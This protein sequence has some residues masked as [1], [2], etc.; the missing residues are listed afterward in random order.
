MEIDDTIGLN[1]VNINV[2]ESLST[3]EPCGIGNKS[4]VFCINRATVKNLRFVNGKYVSYR[5]ID[6]AHLR[7]NEMALKE[8]AMDGIWEAIFGVKRSKIEPKKNW[9]N[10]FLDNFR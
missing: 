8:K 9:F 4:P 7:G 2:I 6:Q 3:L 1:D 10:K 5:E